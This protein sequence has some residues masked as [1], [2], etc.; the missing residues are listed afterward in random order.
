[1][2]AV[3]AFRRGPAAQS[4]RRT[5]TSPISML[6]GICVELIGEN[7]LRALCGKVVD[8]AVKITGSDYGTMQRLCPADHPTHP[9]HLELLYARGSRP[10]PRGTGRWSIRLP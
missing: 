7:D 1:M 2:T 9:G 5:R 6:H 10:R 3:V 4:R 8:A